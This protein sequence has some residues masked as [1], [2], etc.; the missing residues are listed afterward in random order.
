MIPIETLQ[1]TAILPAI[2]L[3]KAVLYYN[4]Q[5]IKIDKIIMAVTQN[6]IAGGEFDVLVNPELIQI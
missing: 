3:D 4:G 5:E 1:T 6:K 2:Y